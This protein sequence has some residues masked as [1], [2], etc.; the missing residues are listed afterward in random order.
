ME[1]DPS[2]QSIIVKNVTHEK[3]GDY[4]ITLILEDEL[5]ALRTYESSIV[6]KLQE[7]EEAEEEE[8]EEEEEEIVSTFQGVIIPTE[9]EGDQS[10]EEE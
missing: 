5:G 6:I 7:K 9:E 2:T 8:V 1:F 3:Q 10:E 4:D